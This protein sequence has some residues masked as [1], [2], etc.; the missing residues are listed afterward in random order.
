MK[1]TTP[2]TCLNK[3]L[4]DVWKMYD[5]NYQLTKDSFGE[6]WD[7]ECILHPTNSYCKIFDE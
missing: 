5:S 1:L 7:E 4:N 2:L 6:Y 3:P